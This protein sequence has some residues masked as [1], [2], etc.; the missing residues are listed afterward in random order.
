MH[1]HVC[2]AWKTLNNV[3]WAE[4]FKVFVWG[5][6]NQR[7]VKHFMLFFSTENVIKSAHGTYF[8][9]W[10]FNVEFFKDSFYSGLKIK[11][12]INILCYFSSIHS[13]YLLASKM[14]NNP[15]VGVFCILL[16]IL[17]LMI[18]FKDFDKKSVKIL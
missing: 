13:I 15:I 11:D 14:R 6:K 1:L 16:F 5:F 4:I 12:V 9:V 8:S 2:F 17:Y 18:I 7:N 10:I 3:I